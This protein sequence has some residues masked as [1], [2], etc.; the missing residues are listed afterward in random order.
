MSRPEKADLPAIPYPGIEPFTY[1]ERE[2]F[3]ARASEARRLIRLIALYRGVLLYSASGT[4]KSS[5][6]NAGVIP[7]AIREGYQPVRLR[8]QPRRNEEILV[9]PILSCSSILADDAEEQTVLS[10]E[11][12]LQRTLAGAREAHP[13]LIFDQFEEWVTLFEETSRERCEEVQQC[14]AR[15]LDA[16]VSL[17]NDPQLPVKLLIVFREDYLASLEPLFERCPNLP[18]HYLRLTG[19]GGEPL[20][21]TIRGPFEE[22]PGV[23]AP[24]IE[25]PLAAEIVRQL[26][27]RAEGNDAPLTEA[28]IVCRT[29]FEAG[30]RGEDPARVFAAAGGVQGILERFLEGALDSLG[31]KLR[32]P[33]LALLCR[34][35]TSAGTRNVISRDDLLERVAL[36]DQIPRD[37]L[38]E[39]LDRLEEK[40]HLVRKERRRGVDF[41]E[42]VS[43]FLI[44]WIRRQAAHRPLAR[45]KRSI[46]RLRFAAAAAAVAG[47]AGLAL[48]LG[49]E[50]QQQKL[51]RTSQ[52]LAVESRNKTGENVPQALLLAVESV[53]RAHRAGLERFPM[54]EESLRQALAH[55]PGHVLGSYG[56]PV[57]DAALSPDGR[58]AAA[59]G[60]G[61]ALYLWR[62][63]GYGSE[64]DPVKLA[65]QQERLAAVAVSP[66]GRWLAT[67]NGERTLSLWRLSPRAARPRLLSSAAGK[68][69]TVRFSSGGQWLMA[70]G[71]GDA[72]QVWNLTGEPPD[73]GTSLLQRGCSPTRWSHSPSTRWIAVGCGN[74]AALLWDLRGREPAA[75]DLPRHPD[76]IS[77]LAFSPDETRLA[78]GSL[79]GTIRLWNLE[80]LE[81]AAHFDE[82]PAESGEISALA[83]HPDGR[84]LAVG[85]AD[86]AVRLREVREARPRN[87]EPVPAAWDTLAPLAW[88]GDGRWLFARGLGGQSRLWTSSPAGA[89]V[90]ARSFEGE[91]FAAAFSPDDRWLAAGHQNG[92]LLRLD[93][94]QPSSPLISMRACEG[95]VRSVSFGGGGYWL[96]TRGSR[97]PARLWEMGAED[98]TRG[99]EPLVSAGG[100]ASPAPLAPPAPASPDGK[101]RIV[102]R[103][104]VPALRELSGPPI[105]LR[106]HDGGVTEWAFSGDGRWLLTGGEDGSARLWSLGRIRDMVRANLTPDPVAIFQHRE[107]VTAALFGPD[108]RWLATLG[109]TAALWSLD[110]PGRTATISTLSGDLGGVTQAAFNSESQW[111]AIGRSDGGVRLWDL[112]YGSPASAPVDLGSLGSAVL[113]LR[114]DAGSRWLSAAS[115]GGAR[116]W[117]VRLDELMDL[118]CRTAGRS[119]SQE[120]WRR[121]LGDEPYDSKTC[122]DFT[123][124]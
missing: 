79:D 103:E 31:S 66:D 28:Q 78:T 61:G 120:D 9:E 45:L 109:G 90:L 113:S 105:E 2:V 106:R 67:A 16:L 57:F 121:I 92:T 23:Y 93:L 98:P 21:R 14:R 19:L 26:A 68:L 25:P 64:Q 123:A 54:A 115:A 70:T 33:A 73:A 59:T 97:G 88:S 44:D 39:A 104:D 95:P 29:L 91:I 100:E 55:S 99:D 34:M 89:L 17:I 15:V 82:L 63:S 65:G 27:S 96:L 47:L 3:F 71:D 81:P 42:I 110:G 5:L 35:I 52:L 20:R 84:W 43:E 62:V 8:V 102:I 87:P 51:L 94:S 53:R 118:A 108:S 12:F 114:F 80:G 122:P 38:G 56:E 49:Q 119:L 1:A 58:W 24:E 6:V 76:E 101:W 86:G 36:A 75:R 32:D 83:F 48:L 10:V 37:R 111:L 85:D 107:A 4:G 69:D 60:K 7:L 18:D 50:A 124:P 22:H 117:R 77:A 116:R 40:T 13:L 74:G 46:H 41:Y 72:P 30:L 11:T 112:T